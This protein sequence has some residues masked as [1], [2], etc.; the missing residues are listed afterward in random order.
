MDNLN[1]RIFFWVEK[2]RNQ[3]QFFRENYATMSISDKKAFFHNHQHLVQIIES[4]IAGKTKITGVNFDIL[5]KK[6]T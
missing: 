2:A 1:I 6:K 3:L 4:V 5:N